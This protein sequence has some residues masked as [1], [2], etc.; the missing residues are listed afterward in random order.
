[1]S[2][3]NS[4]KNKNKINMTN[5]INFNKRIINRIIINK[6]NIKMIKDFQIQIKKYSKPLQIQK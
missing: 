2:N 5:R 1:M 4:N 3:K 6:M